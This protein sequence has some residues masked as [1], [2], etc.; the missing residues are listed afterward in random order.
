[1]GLFK[2]GNVYWMKKVWRGRKVEES[3]GT[4]NKKLAERLY[5]EKLPMIL[6]GS[7]FQKP[8]EAPRMREVIERYMREVSP[9]HKGHERNRQIAAHW[10][11]FFED[12][13][14]CDVTSDL[15]STYKAGRIN[16]VIKYGRGTGRRAGKSCVKKE[17]SFLRQVF[18]KAFDEWE[19]A[20]GGYFRLNQVNP[21]RK[22]LKGLQDIKRVRYIMPE[23]AEKLAVSLAQSKMRY[24]HDMVIIGC[25]SGLRESRIVHLAVSQCDFHNGRINI[26]GDEMK[27]QEPFSIKM[28][29]EVKSTL[30]RILRERKSIS[31]YVFVDEN[32]QP[33]SREEV[34]M[35]FRRACERAG[36][37]DLRF[38]DL[39]HDF[40]T[41][42][43]NS[44]ATLYQVQHALGHKDQRMTARYAHLLPENRDVV[45]LVEGKGT[46]TI[47]RQSK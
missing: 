36:V 19:N 45:D 9:Q 11:D 4:S 22:V 32:G 6:D 47:L 17:L 1:M 16:G 18:N 20:W 5:A 26:A 2:R 3:L 10:Y 46:A 39:R 29:A 37:E 27:N 13:L 21:V 30:Q 38:H 41:I 12:K 35:A 28:T 40:A 15:L 31:P 43:I 44:G 25:S 8:V 24:L 7:Y 14:L 33:Y 34:S 23:E 42:L